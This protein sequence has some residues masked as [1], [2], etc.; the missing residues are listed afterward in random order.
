MIRKNIL[1]IIVA[2][3]ILYLSLTSS[4]TF[5]RVPLFN[6]PNLDK[7][8]HFLMYAG[9]MF[10]ILF[11]NRKT[12]TRQSQIYLTAFIPFF[13]GILM[14]L[15]QL[16]LTDTRSGSIYDALANSAG[17]ITTVLIWL[18]IK[19]VIFRKSDSK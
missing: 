15:L 19:P 16:S 5:N 10:V 7:I 12:L 13:Y 11:E 4:D 8:V 1:S 3:I 6:I 17:I 2:F 9:L 14:E 18:F